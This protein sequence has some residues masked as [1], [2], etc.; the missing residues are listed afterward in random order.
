VTDVKC[1]VRS[2][3]YWGSGDV[4]KADTILVDNN[5]GETRGTGMEAGNLDLDRG[6]YG[7]KRKPDFEAGTLDY[8]RDDTEAARTTYGARTKTGF[9]AGDVTAGVYQ[10]TTTGRESQLA[11]TSEATCCRTFRPKGTP[12]QS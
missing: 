2:C 9:E 6:T 8:N 12:R 5:V 4:C 11:S 7:T 3:H 1:K 10:G